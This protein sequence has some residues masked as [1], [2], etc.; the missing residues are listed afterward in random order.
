M[1]D[2]RPEVFILIRNYFR[3]PVLFFIP[4]DP[5]EDL[6]AMGQVR[7]DNY[8]AFRRVHLEEKIVP[9]IDESGNGQDLE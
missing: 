9:Q 7:A 3:N 8:A 2:Q 6:L 4:A 5:A 1:P